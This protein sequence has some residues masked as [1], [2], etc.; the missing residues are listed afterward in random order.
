MW[1]KIGGLGLLGVMG[2]IAVG[3]AVVTAPDLIR[4]IKISRM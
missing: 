3:L 1:G 2:L 4:Y